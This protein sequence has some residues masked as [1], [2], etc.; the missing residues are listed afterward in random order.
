MSL[1]TTMI[2]ILAV[3]AAIWV[4]YDVV[5][6]NKGLSSLA[7]VLWIVFAIFFSIIT[8]IVYLLVYKVK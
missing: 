5:T 7:K 1:G 6:Y 3:I 2:G 8:A 4:I